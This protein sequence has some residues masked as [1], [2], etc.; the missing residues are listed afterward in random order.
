MQFLKWMI[1]S[2]EEKYEKQIK[3]LQDKCDFLTEQLSKQNETLQEMAVCL[4]R[5]AETDDSLYRDI[6]S[7]A[8]LVSSRE[9]EDDQY[10]TFRKKDKD[11][12]L[13]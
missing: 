11:E 1:R 4:R 3:E 2:R 8:S 10:F 6:L 12:Y 7:L 5:L 9:L 13:N